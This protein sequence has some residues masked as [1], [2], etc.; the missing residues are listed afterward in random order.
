MLISFFSNSRNRGVVETE[1]PGK[2]A[3]A[4]L[5]LWI[6][7]CRK[8]APISSELDQVWSWCPTFPTFAPCEEEGIRSRR[9]CY[10]LWSIYTVSSTELYTV[11]S[12]LFIPTIL[13]RMALS[14]CFRLRTLRSRK[15]QG[16]LIGKGWRLNWAQIYIL[17]SHSHEEKGMGAFYLNSFLDSDW[18]EHKFSCPCPRSLPPLVYEPAASYYD[19]MI[20]SFL[21]IWAWI[22]G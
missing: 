6:S 1:S 20:L 18:D 8:I 17:H 19:N 15:S 16:S 10:H 9:Q 21:H 14:P 3:K 12:T 5:L 11:Y 7:I 22:K 13:K 4:W 2:C